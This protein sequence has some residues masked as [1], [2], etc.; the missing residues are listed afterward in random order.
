MRAGRA[1]DLEKTRARG[2]VHQK[3]SEKSYPL[4][5]IRDDTFGKYRWNPDISIS[6]R[7]YSTQISKI[8]QCRQN[9]LITS[10]F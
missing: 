9:L 3:T 7:R 8:L 4:R 2:R 1:R 6:F 10:T 5:E